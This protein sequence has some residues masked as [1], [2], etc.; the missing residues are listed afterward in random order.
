MRLDVLPH[1]TLSFL[2]ALPDSGYKGQHSVYTGLPVPVPYTF[3]YTHLQI[4]T[5][6]HLSGSV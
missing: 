2:H 3:K 4:Y 5:S 1:S 6:P